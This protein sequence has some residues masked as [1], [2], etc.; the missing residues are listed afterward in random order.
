M[1]YGLPFKTNLKLEAHSLKS[2]AQRLGPSWFSLKPTK[3]LRGSLKR[4]TDGGVPV[5]FS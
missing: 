3:N 2:P 4:P 1:S 5:G